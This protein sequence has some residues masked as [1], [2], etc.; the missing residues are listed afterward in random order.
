MSRNDEGSFYGSLRRTART[1]PA[2]RRQM[3]EVSRRR[4]SRVNKLRLH[5]GAGGEENLKAH[6]RDLVLHTLYFI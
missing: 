2:C 4:E 6:L 3:V 5:F 1:A